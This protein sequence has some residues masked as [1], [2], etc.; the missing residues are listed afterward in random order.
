MVWCIQIKNRQVKEGDARPLFTLMPAPS[1]P[2]PQ[3]SE[4]METSS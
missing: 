2:V 1:D 3:G 4:G